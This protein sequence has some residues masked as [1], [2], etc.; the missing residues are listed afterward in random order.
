LN[1]H[2]WRARR[3][4]FAGRFTAVHGGETQAL[5]VPPGHRRV[6]T[7]WPCVTWPRRTMKLAVGEVIMSRVRAPSPVSGRTA[8]IG[9]FRPQGPGRFTAQVT[10]RNFEGGVSARVLPPVTAL[11][12]TGEGRGAGRLLQ[13]TPRPASQPSQARVYPLTGKGPSPV[14]LAKSVRWGRR[15][16]FERSRESTERVNAPAFEQNPSQLRGTGEQASV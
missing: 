9:W 6:E 4:S 14:S 3:F 8:W 15:W 16:R 13:M 2:T 5:Q 1:G 11:T 10:S 7:A 12:P